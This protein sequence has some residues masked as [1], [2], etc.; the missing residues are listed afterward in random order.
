MLAARIAFV[1]FM[2]AREALR[3]AKEAGAPWPWSPDQILS[4]YKFTNVKRED[5]R[6]TRWMRANWTGPNLDRPGGEIVFNC[7]LFRYFGTTEFAAAVGWRREW[8]PDEVLAT[9][10]ARRSR[11]ER[12]FTGAYIVPTLGHR[13]PKAEAV[14][15]HVLTPLWAA[16]ERLAATALRTAS[17]RSVA[18][19]LRRL[20]GFGGTGFLAKEVLQ[21]VIRT[22]VLENAVDRDTWCPAGPGARRGLNRIFGRPVGASRPERALLAEMVG[23]LAF[24]RDRLPAHMPGL[25]LHDIQFQ[26]CEFDK[27]ER[28][29]LGEGRPRSLYRLDAARIAALVSR[30]EEG[31]GGEHEAADDGER[32]QRSVEQLE[33][34][35]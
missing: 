20:P 34:S 16:R 30:G 29:R 18:A 2:V 13:G 35:L 28:V 7:A 26:L 31:P 9:A 1:E 3:V 4:R 22:P 8:R 6:T 12:V 19:E 21:D 27:Y 10:L 17:W 24:A 11:G 32:R 23:L 25:E 33:I 15:H 14:V 5:D